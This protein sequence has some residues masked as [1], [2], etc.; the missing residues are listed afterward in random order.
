MLPEPAR[1]PSRRTGFDELNFGS[2][3]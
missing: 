3:A 1:P 2:G